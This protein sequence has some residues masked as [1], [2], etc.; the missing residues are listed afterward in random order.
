MK[1]GSSAFK[2]GDEIHSRTL[3]RNG[4]RFNEN[5]SQETIFLT[6]TLEGLVDQ[7]FIIIEGPGAACF[8]KV[9]KT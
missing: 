4:D 6:T 3:T 5:L 9:P 8:S 1:L 7:D 2:I